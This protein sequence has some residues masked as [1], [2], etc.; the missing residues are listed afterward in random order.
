MSKNKNENYNNKKSPDQSNWILFFKNLLWPFI[1][2]IVV[3][4]L[5]LVQIYYM[6]N[7]LK[8]TELLGTK[9]EHFF[10]KSYLDKDSKPGSKPGNNSIT[11]QNGGDTNKRFSCVVNTKK[12]SGMRHALFPYFL[13]KLKSEQSIE[14]WFAQTIYNITCIHNSFMAG[15][16]ENSWNQGGWFL[17]LFYLTF[18]GW[19][20]FFVGIL[21]S[22]LIGLGMPWYILFKNLNPFFSSK[23]WVNI[24]VGIISFF[25]ICPGLS[26]ACMIYYP[27]KFFLKILQPL[28]SDINGFTHIIKCNITYISY[29][30]TFIMVVNG[31]FHLSVFVAA[32]MTVM[33]LGMG[34]SDIYN[35]YITR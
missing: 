15:I 19:V 14:N 29:I 35:Y 22:L 23:L 31:W 13:P 26:S 21:F 18:G 27:M 8:L 17:S 5:G 34:I 7:I 2:L 24:L 16:Y 12:E 30:L 11:P 4:Y 28:L 10:V 25:T 20:Y 32:L 9:E 1:I 33:W 6:N 3:L